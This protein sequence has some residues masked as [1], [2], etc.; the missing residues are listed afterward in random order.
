[1][2][3]ELVVNSFEIRRHAHG[4]VQITWGS[5]GKGTASISRTYQASATT[6]MGTS[7]TC[8]Y[9]IMGACRHVTI[10]I[11]SQS[12]RCPDCHNKARQNKSNNNN[13]A[14]GSYEL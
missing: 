5:S 7:L 10:N 2:G 13:T 4:F 8:W 12:K 3:Q 11:W 6:N 9:Y 1:M 14:V